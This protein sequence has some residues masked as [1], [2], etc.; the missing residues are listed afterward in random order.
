MLFSYLKYCWENI[1]NYNR[2]PTPLHAC[3]Q[4]CQLLQHYATHLHFLQL[5]KRPS[6]LPPA[7]HL[8]SASCNTPAICLLQHLQSA[9]CNTPAICGPHLQFI[10]STRCKFAVVFGCLLHYST[11]PANYQQ[12]GYFDCLVVGN[13]G[14][15]LVVWLRLQCSLL[16]C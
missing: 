13:R 15:C 5:I 1:A 10:A 16:L 4:Y 8:Q 6:N 3:M 7:T 9:S 14:K 11:V 12:I 2:H